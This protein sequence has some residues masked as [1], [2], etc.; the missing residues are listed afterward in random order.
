MQIDQYEIKHTTLPDIGADPM[1]VVISQLPV[2]DLKNF[3]ETTPGFKQNVHREALRRLH[4]TGLNTKKYT[5]YTA[6]MSAL[7]KQ[8]K[9][10]KMLWRPVAAGGGGFA[11]V[12]T[13]GTLWQITYK[14]QVSTKSKIQINS[15]VRNVYRSE[16]EATL[17]RYT[18]VTIDEN[19]YVYI[20]G[21]NDFLS[22]S[23]VPKKID[24]LS[25][26]ITV[27]LGSNHCL[28]VDI[29]GGVYS[30]GR[31]QKGQCGHP[32]TEYIEA[33]LLITNNTG[34]CVQVA[35][36]GH[37][38]SII[39]T[40]RGHVFTFG[41]DYTGQLGLGQNHKYDNENR[42]T[43]FKAT[44]QPVSITLDGNEV[45]ITDVAAGAAHCIAL[46]TQGRIFGW[47]NN[48]VGQLGEGDKDEQY[49]VFLDPVHIHLFQWKTVRVAAC[50]SNTFAWTAGGSLFQWGA[51][52][53]A[54]G[55]FTRNSKPSYIGPRAITTGSFFE[56]NII[57][58][59]KEN[60]VMQIYTDVDENNDR[61]SEDAP[62]WGCIGMKCDQQSIVNGKLHAMQ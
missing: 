26:I 17:D 10:E 35:A 9:L 52:T 38:H 13:D 32:I 24:S 14:L 12:V 8:D 18:N 46:D 55:H 3:A 11:L 36:A 21:Q 16:D 19:G 40:Q 25:R 42:N 56:E 31:N 59:T 41:A 45:H 51:M 62:R 49:E 27:A 23:S 5:T 20:W 48:E 4:S 22:L 1:S 29:F 6:S 60:R 7:Q 37:E 34:Q 61:T 47:G 44:P 50:T 33:P 39:V 15:R 43:Y 28:A 57:V 30:W 53:D 54:N 58:V 2:D